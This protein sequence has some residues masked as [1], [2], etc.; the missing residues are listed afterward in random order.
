MSDIFASVEIPVSEKG[1]V[2]GV[3]VRGVFQPMWY[4]EPSREFCAPLQHV[5]DNWYTFSF[6]NRMHTYMIKDAMVW[7]EEVD[8]RPVFFM[9]T[10]VRK[11][12]VKVS[13]HAKY[14]I[15]VVMK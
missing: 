14:D 7:F 10:A 13:S 8:E 2:R 12:D 15:N 4:T 1:R 11:V 9:E 5:K 3:R 6:F